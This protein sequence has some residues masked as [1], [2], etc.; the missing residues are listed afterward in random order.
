[1]SSPSQRQ[2]WMTGLLVAVGVSAVVLVLY[3][4]RTRSP[5]D[6][7]EASRKDAGADRDNPGYTAA[8]RSMLLVTN[9][10]IATFV[11]Q[12]SFGADAAAMISRGPDSDSFVLTCAFASGNI[13][14]QR[15][16]NVWTHGKLADS[17]PAPV[18][19]TVRRVDVAIPSRMGEAIGAAW[20]GMLKLPRR[21]HA[22][23]LDG[24]PARYSAVDVETEAKAEGSANCPAGGRSAELNAIGEQLLR[25]CDAPGGLRTAIESDAIRR[26][27]MVWMSS[28][29]EWLTRRLANRN[30]Q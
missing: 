5:D 27:K 26:A 7:L 13:W 4:A 30:D 25:Y 3:G 17:D 15:P 24:S 6:Y 11:I 20:S 16:E 12:P 1:M 18:P 22:L 21:D 23:M 28:R 19:L 29:W 10:D 2:I 8:W 9:G 14:Y